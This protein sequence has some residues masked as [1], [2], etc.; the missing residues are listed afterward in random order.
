[1]KSKTLFP[2]TLFDG[3]V[4]FEIP[5]YQ[6]PYVWDEENQWEPLWNDIEQLAGIVLESEEDE[7][8]VGHFLGAIVLKAKPAR[9]GDVT[10]FEVV[11]GQ[12]RLTTLQ[13]VLNAACQVLE[14][15]DRFLDEADAI[16]ELT[17]NKRRSFQGTDEQFK[18][19]PSR[20]DREA[21]KNMLQGGQEPKFEDHRIS[22]AA[23]FFKQKIANWLFSSE[24]EGL[25]TAKVKA[26]VDVIETRL[27]I[28]SIDLDGSDD[29]QLIFETLNDRGTPLLKADLVKNHIFYRGEVLRADTEKWADNYWMLFEDE[30]WREEIRQ[31]RLMRPRID[32]FLNYWLVMRT[33]SEVATRDLFSAFRNYAE[34]AMST[35]EGAEDLLAEMTG[36]A[37]LYQKLVNSESS[38]LESRFYQLVIESFDLTTFMPIILRLSSPSY[39]V[40]QSQIVIAY[41]AIESWVIRRTLL[42]GSTK[43]VNR[44][45]I[46]L[47]KELSTVSGNAAGDAVVS[48]LSQQTSDVRSWPTDEE[49]LRNAPDLRVYGQIKQS[50]LRVIFEGVEKQLRSERHENVS[51]PQDLQI[52]HIMPQKWHQHWANEPSIKAMDDT[53]V[54]RV[55]DLLGNLTLTTGKLNGSLSNRPWTDA[56][57]A[58]NSPGGQMPGQGKRSLI[59]QYSLL[60]LNK[61]I[62][63]R[64]QDSWT[65]DDIRQRTQRI[66]EL[67]CKAWPRPATG[68][69][70]EM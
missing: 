12:Q 16:R 44:M 37:I 57:T 27:I 41:Q 56:A 36:D 9:T 28:V 35:I 10:R 5:R 47:L 53:D 3:T 31:G 43:D 59:G 49:L 66:L 50:R 6:R 34:Q 48:Y 21:F 64:H 29:D 40:P 67:V 13:L 11:D 61:E 23:Q 70:E 52:E 32:A 68:R 4:H 22:Q 30:W 60:A 19:S 55:V 33:C 58:E 26:L 25:V 7:L 14:A 62:V 54:D 24:D 2:R 38:S 20:G 46:A 69:L 63:D 1:M 65:I 8:E 15:D 18:L 39:K 51:L 42:R 45:V 17:T